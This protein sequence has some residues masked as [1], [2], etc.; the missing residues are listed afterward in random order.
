MKYT[1]RLPSSCSGPGRAGAALCALLAAA[2]L[3]SSGPGRADAQPMREAADPQGRFTLSLPAGWAAQT[4]TNE[5]HNVFV[6]VGPADADG[7]RPNIVIDAQ[8]LPQAMTSEAVAKSQESELR[9]L[10]GYAPIR[11]G[12]ISVG[13]LAAYS[14]SFS[15][16]QPGVSLYQLQ[17]YVVRESQV[18][19][20]TGTAHNDRARVARDSAV[21]LTIIKTLRF[22][23]SHAAMPR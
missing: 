15:F 16:T 22:S 9:R 4:A 7:T 12:P 20:I 13:G 14:H 11:E 17:I 2:W 19:V 8:P 10:P 3:A 21:F 1:P 23:P 5:G 6:G 18:Y